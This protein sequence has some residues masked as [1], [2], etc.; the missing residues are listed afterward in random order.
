MM[1]EQLEA[2]RL[3]STV[4]T[5]SDG[6]TV[7]QDGDGTLHVKGSSSTQAVNVNVVEN[8]DTQSDPGHFVGLG[9][10]VVTDNNGGTVVS[11]SNSPFLGQSSCVAFH[12]KTGNAITINGGALGDTI[13]YDGT[14]TK[15]NIQGGTGADQISF[16][17]RVN[18][19]TV[20]SVNGRGYLLNCVFSNHATLNGG[21][22]DDFILVDSCFDTPDVIHPDGLG[23]TGSGLPSG[24]TVQ[25]NNK[26]VVNTQGGNDTVEVYGFINRNSTNTAAGTVSTNS[27]I[28]MGDGSDTTYVYAGKATCDGGN[29]TDVLHKNATNSVVSAKNYE[30]VLNDGF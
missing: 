18:G 16:I 24:S 20:A 26:I 29:G 10:V 21:G 17:D 28:T 19:G 3:L 1:F 23:G 11:P 30:T 4:A 9:N 6:L 22:A 2:R 12:V 14:T 27:Q 8:G 13:N 25:S 15:A 7:T 5:F